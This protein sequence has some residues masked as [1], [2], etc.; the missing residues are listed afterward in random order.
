MHAAFQAHP[1]NTGTIGDADDLLLR[2]PIFHT[3]D[4][5][6]AREYIGGV[7]G[8][9]RV[10][11]LPKERQLDFRHRE[12]KLGPIKPNCVSGLFSASCAANRFAAA[13][14]WPWVTVTFTTETINADP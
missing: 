1:P 6:H 10:A 14:L 2:H 5:E 3:R 12:A 11:Y 8:E 7:F 9:H 4:L 13:K